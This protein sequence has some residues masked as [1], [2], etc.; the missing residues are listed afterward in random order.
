MDIAQFVINNYKEII[1][2][3]IFLYANIK[4]FKNTVLRS[5]LIK[6]YIDIESKPIISLKT[7][8]EI[9]KSNPNPSSKI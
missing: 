4:L 2:G 7:A 3:S 5:S 6:Q 1:S 8:K 9:A